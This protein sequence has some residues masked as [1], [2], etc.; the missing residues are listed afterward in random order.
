MRATLGK[1]ILATVLLLLVTLATWTTS[2]DA[3]AMSQVDAGM[4]RALVS[5]AGARALNAAISLAQGTEFSAGFGAHIT[6][7]VGEVLDPVNDLVESFSNLML[8]ASVAFGIQKVLLMIG[9]DAL[10]KWLLTG[11]V[12]AWTACYLM[13]KQR[14]RWLDVTLILMLMVRFAIPV[15]TLATDGIYQRFLAPEYEQSSVVLEGSTDAMNKTTMDFREQAAGETTTQPETVPAPPTPAP[16]EAQATREQPQPGFLDSMIR[17]IRDNVND[18]TAIASKLDPRNYIEQLKEQASKATDHIIHLMV[19]F[20][21]QTVL[22]PLFLLWA[23]YT[24]LRGVL[25]GA[26]AL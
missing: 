14:Y 15:V 11:V 23:M 4:K 24:A 5:F 13:A 26:F 17:T 19:V 16:A 20:V 10:V 21:L 12:A 6:F 7:S 22:I 18:V 25:A 1:R 9:Q 3:P 2:F 8:L